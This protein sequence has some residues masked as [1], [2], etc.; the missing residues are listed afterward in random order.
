MQKQKRLTKRQRVRQA[1]EEK[2]AQLMEEALRPRRIHFDIESGR[3]YSAQLGL[4][5]LP[6]GL[7]NPKVAQ[8]LI[9]I[10]YDSYPGFI[11]YFR[12]PAKTAAVIVDESPLINAD[13]ASIERRILEEMSISEAIDNETFLR[14][15]LGDKK[16]QELCAT[17][18]EELSTLGEKAME[19]C[20]DTIDRATRQRIGSSAYGER[21][22]RP[23]SS[24][25]SST[26]R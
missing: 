11:D 22:S 8:S 12:K 6:S 9:E 23:A 2:Q 24:S 14:L 19:A 18:E 1:Y 25:N 5:H 15:A 10:F 26:G 20:R 3:T 21:S 7:G 13:Y 16:V 4:H 17:H